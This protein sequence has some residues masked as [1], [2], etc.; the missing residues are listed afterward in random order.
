MKRLSIACMV[1]AVAG[2]SARG[3]DAASCDSLAK[4]VL[5][6]TAITKAEVVAAGT[7]QV[8]RGGPARGANT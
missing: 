1:V 2:L 3:A 5:A 6:D 8:P 4:L 7:I